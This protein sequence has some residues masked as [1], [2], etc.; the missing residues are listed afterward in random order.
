MDNSLISQDIIEKRKQQAPLL[1][2]LQSETDKIISELETIERSDAFDSIPAKVSEYKKKLED[3]RERVE[4]KLHLFEKGVINVAIAD[5]E[6]AGKTTFLKELTGISLPVANARCT[7]VSCEISWVPDDKDEGIIVM[8][9]TEEELLEIINHEAEYLNDNKAQ[10]W[11][12]PE[13]QVDLPRCTSLASFR[14]VRLPN[15][16]DILPTSKLAYEPSLLHLHAI[17]QALEKDGGV[18]GQTKSSNLS[19]LERYVRH[20]PGANEQT[21]IRQVLIKKHYRDGH[22]NLCLCDTPGVDDPNPEAFRR[23]IKT[24]KEKTDMLVILDRPKDSPSITG[25]LAQFI[26]NLESV[27]SKD[28]P[29]RER[30]IFLVNW[31]KDADEKGKWAKARLDE[32]RA[33]NV[34]PNLPEPCDVTDE[35]SR[36]K[37][38]GYLNDKLREVLLVQDTKVVRSLRDEVSVLKRD[39]LSDVV[40]ALEKQSPPLPREAEQKINEQFDDWFRYK[41]PTSFLG[42]LNARFTMLTKNP[43]EGTKV[44]E[45]LGKIADIRRVWEG[46]IKDKIKGGVTEEVVNEILNKRDDPVEVIFARFQV[47]FSEYVKELTAAVVEIA[48]YVLGQV[49]DVL[50]FALEEHVAKRLNKGEGLIRALRGRIDERMKG[51]GV[52]KIVGEFTSLEKVQDELNHISRYELRPALNLIDQQRWG[53]DQFKYVKNKAIE[54]LGRSRANGTEQLVK[55]LKSDETKLPSRSDPP[56]V[57]VQFIRMVIASAQYYMA[58]ILGGSEG[59]FRALIEDYASDASSALCTQEGVEQGWNTILSRLKDVIFAR[60]YEQ[61]AKDSARALQCENIIKR[62][63]DAINA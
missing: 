5:T 14:S 16:G 45:L 22:A 20:R 61:C 53:Y 28:Y 59:K 25:S 58:E 35:T 54:V 7:A 21:L 48:P 8:Y 38:T 39:V 36:K 49:E 44:Q 37:F 56:R 57:H 17:Q 62:L 11:K 26:A 40:Q 12:E 55:F 43:C 1:R 10:V 27:G 15:T 33:K 46:K 60:E 30:A 6:K 41:K 42:R 50:S 2:S 18:L 13:E 32:V 63:R 3:V 19:E 31:Y 29:M 47:L 51:D 52:Q 24:L 4:H 23:T 9:Y 34:I